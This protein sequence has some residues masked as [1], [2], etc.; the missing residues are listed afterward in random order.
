MQRSDSGIHNFVQTDSPGSPRGSPELKLKVCVMSLMKN[1]DR[2][3]PLY[4]LA[5]GVFAAIQT[6][7][8]GA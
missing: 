3:A 5:L 8:L 6:A 7:T 4:L 1:F 2:I